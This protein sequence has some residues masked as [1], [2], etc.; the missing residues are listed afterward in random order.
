MQR[1]NTQNDLYE[2]TG[3]DNKGHIHS[4]FKIYYI[5]IIIKRKYYCQKNRLTDKWN[6]I[7]FPKIDQYSYSHFFYMN[8]NATQWRKE[9]LYIKTIYIL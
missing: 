4:D 1:E 5:F 3:E 9:R 2:T 7:D 8:K 6:K